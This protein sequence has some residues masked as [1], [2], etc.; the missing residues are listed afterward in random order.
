[1]E[2]MRKPFQG[3]LNIIRFNWHFYATALLLISILLLFT[4]RFD[5]SIRLLFYI[6]SVLV[7]IAIL[8][9]LSASFY[10]YDLSGLYQLKWMEQAGSET[11]IVN[12]NAGFDETSVLLYNKFRDAEMIVLD[13]YDPKKNTEISIKRA[14]KAY[15]PFP[16]TKQVTADNLQLPD[17][18]ADKI[19]VILAAHEIRNASERTAFFSGLKRAIKPTGKIY[20]TEHLRDIPNLIAYNIG[21]FHFFSKNTWLSAFEKAGLS[22]K[23]E[24]KLSPF[25]STFILDK[26]GIAS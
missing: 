9:S 7:S 23:K 20:V 14:R 15:P 1:M 2:Q 3:V 19:F 21:V 24:T 18:S 11:L 12:I 4:S 6:S 22:V 25:I 16:T 8:F 10:I 17:N 5:P 26:N 13:F